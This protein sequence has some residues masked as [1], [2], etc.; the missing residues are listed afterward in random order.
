MAQESICLALWKTLM[1][2]EQVENERVNERIPIIRRDQDGT[3]IDGTAEVIVL[4]PGE[5]QVT[6][7]RDLDGNVLILPPQSSFEFVTELPFDPMVPPRIEL[8][9]EAEFDG[10]IK[11]NTATYR[12]GPMGFWARLR[13]LFGRDRHA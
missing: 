11:V 8:E 10:T 5:F 7:F 6:D 3:V 2:A 13:W 12:Y 9:T 1:L 4:E